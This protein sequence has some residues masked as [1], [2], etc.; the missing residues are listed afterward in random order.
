MEV[1]FERVRSGRAEYKG[2]KKLTLT[3]WSF[4]TWQGETKLI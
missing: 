3:T 2:G 1:A 4:M